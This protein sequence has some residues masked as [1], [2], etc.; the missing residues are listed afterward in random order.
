MEFEGVQITDFQESIYLIFKV[1]G[2]KYTLKS[3]KNGV[4]NM[5]EGIRCLISNI[6][7]TDRLYNLLTTDKKGKK[8]AKNGA[9]IEQLIKLI[10]DSKIELMD[11]EIRVFKQWEEEKISNILESLPRIIQ[12]YIDEFEINHHIDEIVKKHEVMSP[13][14]KTHFKK[15]NKRTYDLIRDMTDLQTQK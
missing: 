5:K 2:V 1:D 4:I 13:E 12:S 14:S 9:T 15:N 3:D 6:T 11:H 7:G 8:Y 10:N